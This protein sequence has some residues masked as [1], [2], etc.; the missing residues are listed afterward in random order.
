MR[1]QKVPTDLQLGTKKS[2]K[3][4]IKYPTVGH[5]LKSYL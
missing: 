1:F 5:N 3:H 2:M 4:Q